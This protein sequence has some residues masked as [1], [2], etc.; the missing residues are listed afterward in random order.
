MRGEAFGPNLRRVRVRRGVTLE[1]IAAATN[2]DVSLLADLEINDFSRWPS[3]IYSRAYIRQ[4]AQAIGVDPD[5]AVDEFCRW[6]PQGDRRAER[7]LREHADIVGHDLMWRDD[8]GAQHVN[9][10]A[11]ATP[12]TPPPPRWTFAPLAALLVRLRRALSRA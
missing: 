8:V 12:P 4:Y 7:A 10:R 6:F 9:R 1:E 3:G 11:G 5:A 2:I